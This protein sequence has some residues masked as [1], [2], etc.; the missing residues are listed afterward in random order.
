VGL[1]IVVGLVLLVACANVASLLL[2]RAVERSREMSI[3]VALGAGR[4]RVIR[5]LL[6]ES[7][8]LSAAGGVVGWLLAVWGVRA[9]DR[10]IRRAGAGGGRGAGLRDPGAAGDARGSG[11]CVAFR[12]NG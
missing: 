12:I 5:Q 3:R 7:V 8:T 6:A 10:A 9:F 11:G 4:W 1:W 2:G